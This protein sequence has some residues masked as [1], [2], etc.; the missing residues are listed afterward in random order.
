[1]SEIGNENGTENWTKNRALAPGCAVTKNSSGN[2]ILAGAA[3]EIGRLAL[4]GP[5]NP[6]GN[7]AGGGERD[8]AAESPTGAE[9]GT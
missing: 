1:V 2:R 5:G 7:T 4:R 3:K 8:R 9:R 6:L